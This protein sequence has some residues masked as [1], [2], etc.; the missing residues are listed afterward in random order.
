M[1]G[2]SKL[3]PGSEHTSPVCSVASYPPGMALEAGTLPTSDVVDDAA[4]DDVP[5]PG[6]ETDIDRELLQSAED[7][8]SDVDIAELATSHQPGKLS[9]TSADDDVGRRRRRPASTSAD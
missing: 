3:V 5:E 9:M 4:D 7:V 8:K 1:A 6:P 2:D